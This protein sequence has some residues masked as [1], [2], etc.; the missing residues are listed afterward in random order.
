MSEWNVQPL[1][2]KDRVRSITIS[3]VLGQ[4]VTCTFQME[5]VVVDANDNVMSS[6]GLSDLS[7][8]MATAV[9]DPVLGPLIQALSPSL[10]ALAQAVYQQANP[11]AVISS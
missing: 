11:N 5:R 8:V 3:N 6:A 7:I 1:S 4:P 10:D 9:T 2:S